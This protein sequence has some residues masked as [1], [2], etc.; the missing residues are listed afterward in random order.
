MLL[1]RTMQPAPLRHK[2]GGW[3]LAKHES[4]KFE[5]QPQTEERTD[6]ANSQ[7]RV[8]HF[9][10]KTSGSGGSERAGNEDFSFA[11]LIVFW[12][13]FSQLGNLGGH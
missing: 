9:T 6:S 8:K 1:S 4:N 11:T 5:C 7:P 12:N 2:A 13:C 3:S 10:Q